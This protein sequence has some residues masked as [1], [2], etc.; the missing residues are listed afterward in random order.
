VGTKVELA[1]GVMVTSNFI[2]GYF[3]IYPGGLALRGFY[4]YLSDESPPSVS[5]E[6]L[7]DV[8]SVGDT[9]SFSIRLEGSR[10][11][12]VRFPDTTIS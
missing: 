6:G 12:D 3:L 8:Y 7:K 9:L 1:V 4:P 2:L 5:F 10:D 11:N